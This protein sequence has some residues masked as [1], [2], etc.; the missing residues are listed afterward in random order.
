MPYPPIWMKVEATRRILYDG[1]CR[2]CQAPLDP[3]TAPRHWRGPCREL[4]RWGKLGHLVDKED[5][6]SDTGMVS[7][8]RVRAMINFILAIT[9][10]DMLDELAMVED[11]HIFDRSAQDALE[12]Q[13]AQAVAQRIHETTEEAE[14]VALAM[15]AAASAAAA[16][17]IFTTPNVSPMEEVVASLGSGS[18]EQQNGYMRVLTLGSEIRLASSS[19]KCVYHKSPT[20]SSNPMP[21]PSTSPSLPLSSQH[22]MKEGDLLV[23]CMAEVDAERLRWEALDNYNANMIG[24]VT[25]VDFWKAHRYDFPLL[26]EIAMDV[27]PVQASSVSSEQAFLSSKMTCTR[28]RNK[29]SAESMEYLQVL[30]HSLHRRRSTNDNNQTLDFMVHVVG[31]DI[32]EED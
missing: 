32:D 13:T 11:A 6:N 25:L 31:S 4:F 23:R 29:I 1:P 27:L 2:M 24:T 30:K 14:E 21:E 7:I 9:S 28:E 20:T 18:T 12:D 22:L 16:R 15:A 26:Y 8:E 17:G 19:S 10:P 5:D 3:N